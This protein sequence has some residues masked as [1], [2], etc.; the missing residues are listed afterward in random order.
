MSVLDR[1]ARLDA[2]DFTPHFR[3]DFYVCLTAR[4]DTLF[5]FTDA[6]LCEDGPVTGWFRN[7]P[8]ARALL[9]AAEHRPDR[10]RDHY[11]PG[12]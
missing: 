9:P 7:A 4:G 8:E 5:E 12:S 1:A 10:A 2:F 11:S 3:E 6:M